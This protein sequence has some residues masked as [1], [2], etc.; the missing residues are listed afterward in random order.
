MRPA[1]SRRT[2]ARALTRTTTALDCKRVGYDAGWLASF[3]RPNVEL[4]SSAITAVTENGIETADG[5]T[6][7]VDVIVWATGFQVTETGVGLNHG[8]YGEDGIELS[9]KYKAHGGAYGFLGVG[10]PE[11]RSRRLSSPCD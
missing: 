9:E 1:V 4:V 11:V 3:R 10:L 5:K 6:F 2:I 7:D 8:V